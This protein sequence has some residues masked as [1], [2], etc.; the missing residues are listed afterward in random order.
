MA[1]KRVSELDFSALRRRV[2]SRSPLAWED[3]VLYFLMLDRFS[4]EK[5]TDFRDNDGNTVVAAGTPRYQPADN[6]SAVQNEADA[7]NWRKAESSWAELLP[8]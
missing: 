2:F 8:A 6:G 3:E 1:E 5:E 4:D 7:S